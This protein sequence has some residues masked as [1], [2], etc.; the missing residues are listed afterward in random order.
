M[1]GEPVREVLP[2]WCVHGGLFGKGD[3]AFGADLARGD[4]AGFVAEDKTRDD[5]EEA[6]NDG[7]DA[8]GEKQ[9]PEGQAQR[10]LARRLLVHVAEHVQTEDRHG[11]AQ[12][13]EAVARAEQRPVA[14]EVA[15][16]ERALGDDK[17]Y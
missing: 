1:R 4:V 17:E 14:R 13:D 8:R 7:E 12:S 9:P 15:P 11:A 10:R 6:D 16:E 2:V 3:G 5:V